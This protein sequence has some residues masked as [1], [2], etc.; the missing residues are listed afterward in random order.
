MKDTI[1]EL[2]DRLLAEFRNWTTEEEV[3]FGWIRALSDHTGLEFE[4]ERDR[5]D[6]Y[7]NKVVLEFKA[8]G[9]FNGSTESPA[10]QQAVLD[11][12]RKYIERRAVS[13]NGDPKDYVG[14]AIDGAHLAF[15][16][17]AEDEITH[18]F[19]MP[20]EASSLKMVV[21]TCVE[22]KRRAFNG[23]NVVSDF[24]H[25]S[26]VGAQL[27]TALSDSLKQE[28]HEDENVKVRMLYEEWRAFFGQASDLTRLQEEAI[29]KGLSFVFDS[30]SHQ[31][32]ES[33]FVIHTYNT[34]VI[35]LVAAHLLSRIGLTSIPD[36]AEY[37]ST[38][39]DRDLLGQLFALVESGRLYREAGILNF[40]EE[41]LFSWYVDAAK[42]PANSKRIVDGI[43]RILVMVSLYEFDDLE[44]ARTHDV[45]KLLYQ[46][47]VPRTLRKALGE[48]YTP[49]WLVEHSYSLAEPIDWTTV[50]VLDPTCGSGS[51]V[52]KAIRFKRKALQ[53]HQ[54]S[55]LLKSILQDVCGFDLSPLA[56]Q[57]ARINYLIAISDLLKQCPGE[58]IEIPILF[59]DAVYSPAND[60]ETEAEE[61][62]V[63]YRIGSVHSDLKISL[64]SSVAFDRKKTD[65]LFWI[66]A[67]N[68]AENREPEELVARLRKTR[69]QQEANDA[70]WRD[71]VSARRKT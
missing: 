15:A 2:S 43:R 52:I 70:R 6:A 8:P 23:D 59:A 63:H 21:A 55:E 50:R 42:S 18:G 40:V 57:T 24:G 35:K 41:V 33:L 5:N 1:R 49:D 19:L 11:R 64:P 48:F 71:A 12:L 16:R 9:L 37:M 30:D 45:L 36:F 10:F 58:E 22:S 46:N 39:P 68:V 44:S 4:L 27:M 20:V 7:T 51:F 3:R 61:R 31:L 56:V 54:A 14:I 53:K 32:S 29:R 25:Q 65:D 69:Y 62:T 38:L 17:F 60:R 47:L 26:L 67:E 66:L 28:L 13:D 34:L